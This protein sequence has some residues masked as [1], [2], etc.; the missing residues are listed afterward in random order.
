MA[1][2]KSATGATR[3]FEL[4]TIERDVRLARRSKCPDYEGWAWPELDFVDEERWR[5][6]RACRCPEAARRLRA[7][8][9]Q[10]AG[11]AGDRV[12]RCA[13][14]VAIGE[15]N[16]TCADAA[17]DRQGSG[18]DV[19][20][21]EEVQLPQD[22]AGQLAEVPIWRDP[23]TCQGD[24]TRSPRRQSRA[25]RRSARPAGRFLASAV[26]LSDRQLHDLFTAA[27]VERRGD[28]TGDQTV[29]GG[30]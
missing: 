30:R 28:T 7:A 4:A 2:G 5:A 14:R 23:A 26:M 22:E 13:T 24:L 8:R 20:R 12:H 21:G 10:Q 1:L 29:L 16:A 27:R 25:S 15:G 18:L 17:A 6:A 9:R 19:W 11:A 3:L